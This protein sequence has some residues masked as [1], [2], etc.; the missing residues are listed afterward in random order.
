MDESFCKQV[1]WLSESGHPK[2][3]LTSV[4]EG[5]TKKLKERAR[6]QDLVLNTNEPRKK[7]V[8]IP[9]LHKISHNIG[10]RIKVNVVFSVPN[11]L[12]RLCKQTNPVAEKP[13]GHYHKAPKSVCSMRRRR[14][15][16]HS[17]PVWQRIHRGNRSLHQ[18]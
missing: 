4:A 17:D 13:K 16:P 6:D 1:K 7:I 12:S 10:R 14:C 3:L 5:L 2:P 11:K 8:V 9:Y 18:L 15:L